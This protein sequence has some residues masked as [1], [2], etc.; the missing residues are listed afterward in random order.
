MPKVYG[1]KR[2]DH[3]E[4]GEDRQHLLKAVP[5]YGVAA[6]KSRA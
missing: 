3:G 5:R 2:A 4:G 6:R 1:S